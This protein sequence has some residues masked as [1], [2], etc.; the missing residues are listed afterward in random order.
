VLARYQERYTGIGPTLAAEKLQEE[1]FEVDHETLRRWLMAAGLWQRARKRGQHRTRR[2]RKEHFG[3]LVQFDGSHH[4][5]FGVE[6]PSACLMNLVDDATGRTLATMGAQE[7]T[8]AAML[9]V[10]E[11]IK[12][13]GIPKA[14]YCDR[15]TVYIT[16]REPTVAEQLAEEE[17]LTQFGKACKKL[18]IQII[19]AYS[20][21][22]K[23]RVERNHGVYQDRLFH[24]LRLQGI[25]TIE[26]ADALLQNGFVEQLNEKFGRPPAKPRDLHRRLPK[27]LDLREVFSFEEQRTVANDWTIRHENR[28]FQILK[29]NKPLPKPKEKVVVRTWLDGSIHLV[30]KD[31]KLNYKQLNAPPAKAQQPKAAPACA[32]PP[33]PAQKPADSHPWRKKAVPA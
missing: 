15:K 20:P 25:T 17:P 30:Y 12:Q 13:Y 9:T 7:T 6:H 19:T 21:Q 11:W 31:K 14:L 27:H 8:K 4:A 28:Y 3:E 24:E 32:R 1:G 2:P 33:K 5:W 16:D 22:A 26:A 18:G 23:G 10:W 29:D